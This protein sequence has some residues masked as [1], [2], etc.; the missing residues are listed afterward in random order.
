MVTFSSIPYLN[1]HVAEQVVIYVKS[2]YEFEIKQ[3]P[4]KSCVNISEFI[5][6]EIKRE[7][8]KNVIIGCI[9]RHCT[10]ITPFIAII[11]FNNML[12][13]FNRQVNKP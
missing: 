9:Y 7:G 2:S 13:E 4:S 1:R 6:S 10:P 5:F 11:F 3:N 8:H 12:Q